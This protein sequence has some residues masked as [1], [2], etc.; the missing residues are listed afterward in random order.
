M[1]ISRR[2]FVQGALAAGAVA[3]APFYIN[4]SYAAAKE[5][6]IYAWAGY[7]TDE[8]LAD[9]KA[10]TGIN[11]T[12]TPYGTNDELMNSLRATDGSG[13][14]IIMPTVD[15]VP[16][17]VDFGLVQPLDTKRI[18]WEGC[19]DSAISGSEVGG[20][21][22]GERYFAP[23][24]WGTE[25]ITYNTEKTKLDRNNISYGDLWNPEIGQGVTVR[26]HSALVGIGL[27][28]EKAGKLPFPLLDSYKNEKAMRANFDVIL[29]VATEHKGM[30]AQFWST[31]NE[32]QGAFRT[33]G[34]IIGQT[35]DSTAFKL[36]SEG[37]PIAYAAPKEGALA[38]ME[39]FVI[40][41]NANNVDSVY[42]FIN[43]YYTPDAGA[44]F[45]KSTGYNSTSKGAADLLP[46]ATKKFFTDSYSDADL[47]NLWWWP[48]QDPWYVALRNEYQDRYLAA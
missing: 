28:L 48:I 4:K 36:Q 10:K 37:E 11:A 39:G 24:D 45:V 6:R 7:I 15:R 35:W 2:R 26:G 38:W 40:P 30:I 21:V 20:V 5:L 12:F 13:F 33:N 25:A 8:M 46:E 42:E 34:A 14:D 44:M 1:S 47:K 29:K 9:F 43:W 23:S 41:K 17:Y 16:G 19:L 32:A 27:W 3:S 22:K 31:E 18:K